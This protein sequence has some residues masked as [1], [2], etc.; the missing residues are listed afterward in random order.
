MPTTENLG[1]RRQ[2]TLFKKAHQLSVLC[3]A[4]VAI[5]AFTSDGKLHEFSS[6]S[7]EHTLS[8]YK[9]EVEQSRPEESRR[10][11]PAKLEEPKPCDNYILHELKGKHA[12]LSLEISRRMGKE[13]DDLSREELCALEEQ[14]LWALL[15]VNDKKKELLVE[16]L[17]RS[18][19]RD[20]QR[21]VQEKENLI[22]G[23]EGRMRERPYVLQ[24]HGLNRMVYG[25]KL[26]AVSLYNR[27]SQI[28]DE[29]SDILQLRL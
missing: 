27:P 16:M 25:T 8:R 24:D 15:S 7:M 21:A 23:F 10:H 20:E 13:L 18:M 4:E 26:K 5:I 28:S 11:E 19:S 6:T 29:H 3:D 22:I 14:Q 9:G 2:A 17:Q 1:I 12:A